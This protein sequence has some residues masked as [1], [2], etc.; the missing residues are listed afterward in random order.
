[1]WFVE[2]QTLKDAPFRRGISSMCAKDQMEWLISRA[3]SK[4][5]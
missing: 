2:Q 5:I 3:A 4:Q 1:M